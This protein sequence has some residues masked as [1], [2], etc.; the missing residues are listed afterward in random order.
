[1]QLQLTSELFSDWKIR[2]SQLPQAHTPSAGSSVG[3]A[4]KIWA[5]CHKMFSDSNVY[6]SRLCRQRYVKKWILL[7]LPDQRIEAGIARVEGEKGGGRASF[8]TYYSA[9][10]WW[11]SLETLQLA[12]WPKASACSIYIQRENS[13]QGAGVQVTKNP[14]VILLRVQLEPALVTA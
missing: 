9:F 11:L 2:R 7:I 5:G 13:G 12:M 1:M 4:F 3:A 10:R 14:S 8:Q 6:Y